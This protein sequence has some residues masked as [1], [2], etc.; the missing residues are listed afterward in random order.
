MQLLVNGASLPI[1][2]MGPDFL[3]LDKTMDHPPTEATI[4]FAVAGQRRTALAG[5]SPRR[6]LSGYPAGGD[7]EGRVVF[8]RIAS[9]RHAIRKLPSEAPDT[10]CMARSARH[11]KQPREARVTR[12]MA[13]LRR[14]MR[15]NRAKRLKRSVRVRLRLSDGMARR[16]GAIHQR[17][18]P[19]DETLFVTYFSAKRCF[20][21]RCSRGVAS[22][23]R[24]RSFTLFLRSRAPWT[25]ATVGSGSSAFHSAS[26][27]QPFFVCAQEC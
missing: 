16:S 9:L 24:E 7:F 2:Q 23:R 13:P 20:P 14:A 18:S 4:V 12:W 1:G 26:R 15:S 22:Q 3:L 6:H 10:R 17:S 27:F 25:G 8:R 5:S 21:P 11:G 19:R